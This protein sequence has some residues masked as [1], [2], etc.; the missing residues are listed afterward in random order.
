MG[1]KRALLIATG[2]L[3]LGLG[4]VGV[5]VPGMPTT[6]F[7][8]IAGYC[9]SKSSPRLENMLRRHR[10]LGPYFELA[11]QG[12]MPRRAKGISLL[13]M[14]SGIGGALWALSGAPTLVLA[15]LLLAGCC[16][17]TV[18]LFFIRTAPPDWQQEPAL[19]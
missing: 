14:W 18:L 11:R 17:S 6:V 4:L 5:V 2:W 15:L 9:F 10:T 13:A 3:A 19:G 7:V 12:V 1:A 16:G 8:L